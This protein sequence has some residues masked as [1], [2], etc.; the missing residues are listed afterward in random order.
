MDLRTLALAE[1]DA[2]HGGGES[3]E[4]L[5]HGDWLVAEHAG[6]SSATSTVVPAGTTDRAGALRYTDFALTGDLDRPGD[7]P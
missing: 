7:A 4:Y 1:V 2:R 6:D 5:P 3:L